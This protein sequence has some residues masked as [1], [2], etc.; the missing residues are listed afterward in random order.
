MLIVDEQQ[1][2]I[3]VQ[4][5][6]PRK[7]IGEKGKLLVGII[8]FLNGCVCGK[9]IGVLFVELFSALFSDYKSDT[10][11]RYLFQV[12]DEMRYMMSTTW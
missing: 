2:A 7:P 12:P 3:L 11:Y 9:K 6:E 10:P 5:F 4:Q 8:G 1:P